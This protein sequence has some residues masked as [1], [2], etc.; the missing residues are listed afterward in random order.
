MR[1]NGTQAVYR[2]LGEA[3]ADQTR[4]GGTVVKTS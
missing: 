2:T 4:N 3:N 1:P